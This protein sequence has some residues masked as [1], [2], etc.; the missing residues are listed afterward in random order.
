MCIPLYILLSKYLK[1]F[2]IAFKMAV[3]GVDKLNEIELVKPFGIE[4]SILRIWFCAV[5]TKRH[6]ISVKEQS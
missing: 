3:I 6:Q 1:L 5:D 4:S 2:I